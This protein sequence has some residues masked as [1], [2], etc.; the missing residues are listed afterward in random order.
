MTTIVGVRCKDGVVIGT[1]SSATFTAGQIPTIEQPVD[2]VNVILNMV[3]V[4]GTGAIGLNQRFCSVVES[5][6]AKL[7]SKTAIDV[8]KGLAKAAID[9]FRET[10]AQDGNYGAMV[11]FAAADQP[12]LCEF[13]TQGFQPELKTSKGAWYC[14]MGSAQLITDPFLGFIRDVYWGDE[15]PGLHDGI[16][17]VTWTLQQ[18]IELNAGGVKGP[19]RMAVLEKEQHKARGWKARLLGAEELQEHHT[20]IGSA[21]QLLKELRQQQKGDAGAAALPPVPSPGPD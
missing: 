17:A 14:S 5:N 8:S 21:K 15:V 11:A 16:F 7:N 1:D 12:Q 19:I 4:V 13:A 3:I 2:K 10:Y 20:H 6:W 18:A 9:D